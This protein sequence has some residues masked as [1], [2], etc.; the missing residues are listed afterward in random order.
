MVLTVAQVAGLDLGHAGRQRVEPL[1]LG[2]A[3]VGL[4]ARAPAAAREVRDVGARV[5]Q[6]P[7]ER[8]SKALQH[9]YYEVPN[10]YFGYYRPIHP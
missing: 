6:A 3:L 9:L 8:T 7:L 10:S 1:V 2:A 5:A 4:V